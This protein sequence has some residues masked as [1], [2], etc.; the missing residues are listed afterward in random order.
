[1]AQAAKKWHVPTWILYG[2]WGI[3]TGWG[4]NKN[5]SSAGAM[6]DFQF[7]PA[8]ARAYRY[9]LVNGPND[10]QFAQQADAAAHYLHDEF[11]NHGHD[12]EGALRQYSGH[13][14]G[15]KEVKDSSKG[16]PHFGSG[17]PGVDPAVGAV[18][19][20][21]GAVAGWTDEAGKVLHVLTDRFFWLRVGQILLGVVALAFGVQMIGRQYVGGTVSKFTK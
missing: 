3:E 11:V 10:Q 5:T 16:H 7:M 9:P 19:D 4:K 2:V 6:G 8:T 13:G 21:A 20:A 1:M 17:I 15:L 14:Y 12:W 18:K